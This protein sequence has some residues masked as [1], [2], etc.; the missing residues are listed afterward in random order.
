MRTLCRSD[1]QASRTAIQIAWTCS[2][3]RSAESITRQRSRVVFRRPAPTVPTDRERCRTGSLD[4]GSSPSGLRDQDTATADPDF[5]RRS[6]LRH[7]DTTSYGRPR[8]MLHATFV[9]S[10][11]CSLRTSDELAGIALRVATHPARL[12]PTLSQQQRFGVKQHHAAAV[13]TSAR[14]ARDRTRCRTAV[15][16]AACGA[17]LA[18]R[19]S[20]L[21]RR[22]L[23][24]ILRGEDSTPN[25]MP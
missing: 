11:L 13:G 1:G 9:T 6:T 18:H 8:F 20:F 14:L 10:F 19:G 5:L 22:V 24:I 3:C 2:D 21:L 25:W 12:M 15:A 4:R 17:T 23:P 7:S 16:A